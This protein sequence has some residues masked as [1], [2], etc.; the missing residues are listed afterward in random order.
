MENLI[1]NCI[2]WGLIFWAIKS[3]C[4]AYSNCPTVYDQTVRR[5]DED[6]MGFPGTVSFEET[7]TTNPATGLTMCGGYDAGGNAFGESG[8]TFD[9]F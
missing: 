2:V 6:F 1:V 8:D 9:N 3:L 7:S 4:G 5:D